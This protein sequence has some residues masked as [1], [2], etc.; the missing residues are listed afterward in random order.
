MDEEN[1][2]DADLLEAERQRVQRLLALQRVAFGII[3][4]WSWLLLLIFASLGAL[5][6]IYF[7]MHAARSGQRFTATTRL[8]YSPRQIAKI[9]NFSDKQLLSVLDRRSLKRRVATK[10]EMPVE[11]RECLVS[12]LSVVQEKK[13]TNLFTLNAQA[14]TWVG[15]VKKVNAYAEILID[16]YISYRRRD[17]ENWHAALM[18]R[19]SNL[20]NQIADVDS[21]DAIEKAKT[22]IASPS[23]ALVTLNALVSD[24]RRNCS[25]MNVDIANNELK[26]KKLEE[27]IG[28]HG[29]AVRATGALIRQYQTQL[30]DIDAELARLREVYTDINPK[31]LGKLDDRQAC[32]DNFNKLLHDNGME[33]MNLSEIASIEKAQRE[34]EEC[35]LQLEVLEESRKSLQHEIESNEKRL[36]TLTS[37]IPVLER[38]RVKRAGI[39]EQ[40]RDLDEQL[41]DIEFLQMSIA[42]D[43]QQIERAG[44]A[45]DVN[46]LGIKNFA[47]AIGGAAICTLTVMVW[48]LCLELLFGRVRGAT[49]LGAMGDITVVGSLP[50]PGL[51]SE[52]RENDAMG[53]VSLKYCSCELPKNVVLVCRLPGV[54][55][56]KKFKQTL[57][58]SLSMAGIRA[59]ELKLVP[60]SSFEPPENA[61]SL[62]NTVKVGEKGWFPVANRFML[63]PT[64]LQMLQAD[65]AALA[66]DYDQIFVFMPGGFR[67]GGSFFSQLLGISSCAL[68][69]AAANRTPRSEISYVRRHA[70]AADKPLIGIITGASIAETR[71]EMESKR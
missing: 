49:E 14:P 40:M 37:V 59:F 36:E 30:A 20:Q 61:E 29:K 23:D 69:L 15:V 12:D 17:L 54:A 19:R 65:L 9:Q 71:K 52:E 60:S 6:S 58:W 31:V 5:F 11:E 66:A 4:K 32:L 39:E 51:L 18:L 57:D 21:Q 48:I 3:A 42:N 24:Q 38:I 43:L 35:S 47:L 2:I 34:L 62:I 46:P 55:K 28:K 63:A 27:S 44:G 22:G 41:S 33:G 8:L 25:L 64:E 16:E 10:L 53:F 50:A 1:P 13:P 68:V 67:H 70:R 45:G 7:V 26:R 56:Q